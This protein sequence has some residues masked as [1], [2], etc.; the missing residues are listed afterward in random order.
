MNSNNVTQITLISAT[1][2]IYAEVMELL[3]A[4]R[5]AFALVVVMI[6]MDFCYGI[7]DSVGKRGEHGL[8]RGGGGRDA[9]DVYDTRRDCGGACVHQR[10]DGSDCGV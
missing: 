9:G 1:A 7:A 5:W 2:A 3:F 4:L 10:A 6:M 8:Q